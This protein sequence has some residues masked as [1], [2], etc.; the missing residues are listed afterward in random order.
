M[1]AVFMVIITIIV[2]CNKPFDRTLRSS[3]YSD[4]TGVLGK[5]PK[6]LYLIVDGARGFSVRDANAP[7][8]NAMTNNAI[9]S[10]YSVSDSLSND[11]NGWTD[12]L[13][14]V[15]KAKHKVI[16]NSFANS[17]LVQYPT[18]FKRI[19]DA[20][21]DLRLAAF[22][23]STVFNSKLTANTDV[24]QVMATDADVTAGVIGEL[25]NDAASLV[26][27]EF[28]SVNNAGLASGYDNS[29]PAY[30]SAILQFDQ[31]LG[32]MMAAL[33]ARKNYAK[34]NWLVVITSNHG[35]P[36]T[37]PAAQNDGTIF[38]YAPVNTFTI[39]YNA[40]YNTKLIDKPF[41]GTK[42]T[43]NFA[44]FYSTANADVNSV[45]AKV[46]N[47]N[48]VYNL[49]DT[50]SVTIEL[51]VKKS[52]RAGVYTYNWPIVLSKKDSSLTVRTGKGWS[53]AMEVG[54]WRVLFYNGSNGNYAI[55][56]ANLPDGNWHS[57]SVVILNRNATRVVRLYQDGVFVNEG[58]IPATIG[59][60]D[61]SAPL[62]L[63]YIKTDNTNTFDGYLSDV[64]FWRAA[65]SDAVINK[66]A[67]RT[68]IDSNHPYYSYLVG[69]WKGDDGSG[70][71][72]KDSSPAGNNFKISVG[73]TTTLQWNSQSDIVCPP[74]TSSLSLLVP[75]T[76][77]LPRQILSWLTI[78][79]QDTWQLDGR[80]WLNN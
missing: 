58:V 7:N 30:K 31:Y 2:A 43:G 28:S 10:W 25:N 40:S 75:R 67:C 78:S 71:I 55:N 60:I 29:F 77:D 46:T 53:I 5:T 8:I 38:S 61:N 37:I 4:S 64:R 21:P 76:V 63:G 14:G 65:L 70:N 24:N 19:K 15:T 66:Y 50:N 13:T 68:V 20:R 45:F 26:V 41:T 16:D 51:K 3:G 80:V 79:A 32:Q 42:Y 69:Y 35:G 48:A 72:I 27:G 11:G 59:N 17:N 52:I 34:E 44:H 12:L 36:A 1:V 57:L 23:S 9:Y 22:S 74:S 56:G 47:N 49:G 6:V 62:R 39:L 73:S 18:I 54:T 33:K